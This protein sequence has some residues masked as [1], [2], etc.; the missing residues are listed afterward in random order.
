MRGFMTVVALFVFA[1]E[2][3]AG[4]LRTWNANRPHPVRDFVAK[5]RP[6]ILIPKQEAPKVAEPVLVVKVGKCSYCGDD[7]KCEEGMC[8]SK[9]P[10]QSNGLWFASPPECPNGKCPLAKK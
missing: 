9:C 3:F 7:C 2:G 5:H 8:P 4:P 1:S 6:G 10:V